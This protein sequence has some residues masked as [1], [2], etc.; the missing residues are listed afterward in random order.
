MWTHVEDKERIARK[1]HVCHLCGQWIEP[2]W[3]Y[4]KRFGFDDDGPVKQPMH[5][6]CESLTSS[7][8]LTDWETFCVGD[9]DWPTY[10]EKGNVRWDDV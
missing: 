4:I 7:W 5:I 1:R 8:D 6:E 3:K 9:G 2:G 10:D